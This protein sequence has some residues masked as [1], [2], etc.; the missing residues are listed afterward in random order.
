MMRRPNRSAFSFL[1]LAVTVQVSLLACNRATASEAVAPN[2]EEIA[3]SIDASLKEAWE[4]E[5]I[6]PSEPATDAEYFRRL[7]LDVLGRIPTAAEASAFLDDPSP[8]QDK[9]R[10]AA[11][12]LF[13]RATY[14]VHQTNIWRSI[15]IPEAANDVQ[16][17][18]LVP[19]FEEWLRQRLL[20]GH[21]YDDLVREILTAPRLDLATEAGTAKP[22][23]FFDIR[24]DKPEDLAASTTRAF[25]G[26][27]LECAQCHDHP[28]DDWKQDQF[29]QLAAFFASPEE[30][31]DDGRAVPSIRVMDADRT[32]SAAFPD[33]TTPEADFDARRPL[34]EW[35]VSENNTYFSQ[36]IANRLWAEFFGAGLVEPVD[37]FSPNNPPV[38]P[39][40]LAA[41][42]RAVEET[43]YDLDRVAE[44]LTQTDLY[45][46]SSRSSHPS[47]ASSERFARMPVRALNP[48]QLYDSLSQATGR[49]QTFD[50]SQP[51]NFNGDANRSQFLER[52]A[53]DAVS[54]R[55]QTSS[56]LQALMMMNGE[57]IGDATSLEASRTLTALVDAPFL[58]DEQRVE[59]LYLATYARRPSRQELDLA[60][61]AVQS[62]GNTQEGFADLFW[63]LLNSSE[64]LFNH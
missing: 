12:E 10:R 62:E 39:G 60:T 50:P 27:R 1:C 31:D 46:R 51:V 7:N 64:F 42:A 13:Q 30:F 4:A 43:H 11:T 21:R 32:V 49:L 40:V 34:A 22:T 8:S 41:I 23:A 6:T 52:F 45:N 59:T 17:R 37:D 15:L 33:G 16:K 35:I 53:R 29:W 28:F 63:V 38:Y 3:L 2:V 61:L 20:T 56:I 14:L 19:E 25:L 47:N 55:E 5:E 36:A 58:T 18:Q 44:A 24:D 26:V 48:E 54:S 9:R 57:Y